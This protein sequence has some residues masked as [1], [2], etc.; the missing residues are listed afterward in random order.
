MYTPEELEEKVADAGLAMEQL[1][2]V[3]VLMS[4]KTLAERYVRERKE[5]D[6][7]DRGLPIRLLP[8]RLRWLN[9]ALHGVLRLEAA[10]LS[11]PARA[12]PFGSA[13]LFQAVKPTVA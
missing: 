13:L 4:L 2:Y 3:N 6:Y 1:T 12:L 11:D 8:E 10:Y 5:S 7:D 9:E